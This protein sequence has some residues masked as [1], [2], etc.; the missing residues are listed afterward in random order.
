[1]KELMLMPD[2]GANTNSHLPHMVGKQKI[3]MSSDRL[4]GSNQIAFP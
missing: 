3:E 4:V 1:M 2:Y